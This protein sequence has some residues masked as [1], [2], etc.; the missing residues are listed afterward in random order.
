[1]P[2]HS[3]CFSFDKEPL[4][5]EAESPLNGGIARTGVEKA[6]GN[7]LEL[8]LEVLTTPNKA[9]TFGLKMVP[10]DPDDDRS[11]SEDMWNTPS[12]GVLRCFL[13]PLLLATG[14]GEERRPMSLNGKAPGVREE[15]GAV[16][17]PLSRWQRVGDGVVGTPELAASF[18]SSQIG[19]CWK[20]EGKPEI[21]RGCLRM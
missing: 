12:L 20:A 8:G 1:M 19:K 16:R 21:R 17:R 7:I 2:S 18:M 15:I 11:S 10:P 3:D 6:D 5:G 4:K 14:E 9:C 13:F